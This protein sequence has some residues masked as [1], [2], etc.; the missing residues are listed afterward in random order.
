[1]APTARAT[2]V[3][4]RLGTSEWKKVARWGLGGRR[5]GERAD[6][7]RGW[8]RCE[9]IAAVQGPHRQLVLHIS[10]AKKQPLGVMCKG[11]CTRGHC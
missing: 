6:K 8:A 5:V 9:G 3:S 2:G 4:S 11:L 7:R 1:M 10:A